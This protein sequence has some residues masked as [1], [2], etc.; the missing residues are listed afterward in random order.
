[1]IKMWKTFILIIGAIGLLGCKADPSGA[2]EFQD[3]ECRLIAECVVKTEE[4]SEYIVEIFHRPDGSGEILFMTPETIAGC[5]YLR[6]ASGEYSFQA[7]DMIFPVAENPTTKAIFSLFML[8]EE[9]LIQASTDEMSGET[10][11]ILRFEGDRTLYLGQN[12]QPLYYDHPNVTM[13]MRSMT[14]CTNE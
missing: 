3:K 13:T 1:M 6:T 4:K 12:G 8:S 5:K 14:K 2:L 11:N 10:L 7:D 9:S